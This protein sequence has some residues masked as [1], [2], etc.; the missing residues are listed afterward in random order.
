MD[1]IL[2]NSKAINSLGQPTN[3]VYNSRLAKDMC[4]YGQL[5]NRTTYPQAAYRHFLEGPGWH[6]RNTTGWYESNHKIPIVGITMFRL[7]M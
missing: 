2:P 1:K 4:V 6:D 5:A 3:I 7:L